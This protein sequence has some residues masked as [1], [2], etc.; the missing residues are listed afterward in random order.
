VVYELIL[1]AELTMA[2]GVDNEPAVA[3]SWTHD[4]FYGHHLGSAQRLPN[5]NTLITEGDY[6][7][8]EVTATG[9]VAW[10]YDYEGEGIDE[11]PGAAVWRGY[12]VEKDDPALSFLN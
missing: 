7:F 11:V 9:E 4:D 8:W 5:G 3:W 6:G 12:H 2:P 10:K 1:P